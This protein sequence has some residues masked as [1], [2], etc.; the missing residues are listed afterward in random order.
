MTAEVQRPFATTFLR[1][2]TRGGSRAQL[3]SFNDG[4]ERV[5]KFPN[6]PQGLRVLPN[7]LI[8]ARLANLL[9]VPIP[10]SGI[11]VVTPSFVNVEPALSGFQPGLC[12]G[13]EYHRAV[14]IAGPSEISLASNVQQL[15]SIVVFDTWCNNTDRVNNR[16]NLILTSGIE[17]RTILAIDHGHCFGF[18]WDENIKYAKIPAQIIWRDDF[19]PFLSI[20]QFRPF[21]ELLLAVTEER[22]IRSIDEIPEE[23]QVSDAEKIALVAY[24]FNRRQDVVDII[25]HEFQ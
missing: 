9:N 22:L 11:V 17:E 8:A 5:V 7:E 6:N 10:N 2:L 23:W 3:L 18:Q 14:D 25:E 24:L 16:G 20:P 13:S 12:F 21:F 19:R 1:P 15:A 4:I